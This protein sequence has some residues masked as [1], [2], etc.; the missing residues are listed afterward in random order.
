M[1]SR[2]GSG[3]KLLA[4]LS[5]WLLPAPRAYAQTGQ[6]SIV[7]RVTDPTSA[8][9]M[10]ASITARNPETGFTYT[11]LTNDDGLYRILYVNPGAYEI[12]CE[13]RGFRKV[14]S[15]NVSI[16]STETARVDLI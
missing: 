15:R 7:G 13:A 12:A 1:H 3:V 4:Y 2:I 5:I 16:R 6:G 9:V 8:V 14:V 11:A 10:G